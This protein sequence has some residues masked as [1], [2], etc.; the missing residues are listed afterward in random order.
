[1]A[2]KILI[3]SFWE[4][5]PEYLRFR[6]NNISGQGIP[7]GMHDK[8]A[9]ELTNQGKFPVESSYWNQAKNL[10]DQLSAQI[11]EP[12]PIQLGDVKGHISKIYRATCDENRDILVHYD[13]A[14][15][16]GLTNRLNILFPRDTLSEIQI[17]M[18]EKLHFEA[19]QNLWE[20][21]T[22]MISDGEIDVS[23][24]K[25]S[26]VEVFISYRSYARDTADNLFHTL[27]EFENASIFHPR[28]DHIDLQSGDWIEQL[29]QYITNC[30]VFIPIL[31]QDYLEGPVA[32]EECHQ[33]W[34]L[35]K[36]GKK[37]LVPVLVEG[38]VSDYDETFLGN[39]NLIRAQEGLTPEIIEKIV[40]W[41]LDISENPYDK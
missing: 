2:E 14:Y 25:Q 9:R 22:A 6:V 1:M 41:A 34:R 21:L 37:R 3:D 40:H 10:I 28:I 13:I 32:K 17:K 20:S 12:E 30:D 36:K 11:P 23:K 29:E 5:N 39:Y 24:W 15:E 27:G 8:L 35:L 4:W 26:K 19:N 31:T 18:A 7:A 38:D 16:N 33:A